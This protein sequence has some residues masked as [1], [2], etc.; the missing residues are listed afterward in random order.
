[1]EGR[2]SPC[3]ADCREDHLSTI[4]SEN[5]ASIELTGSATAVL[6][7]S[8][9]ALASG[10]LVRIIM[11]RTLPADD[12]GAFVLG[13][14][15]VSIVGGISSIGLRPATA[16]RVAEHLAAGRTPE[17]VDTSRTALV[18]GLGSGLIGVIVIAILT[19]VG[20]ERF[21]AGNPTLLIALAPVALSLALGMCVL[22][23][24]QGD[25]DTRGR[26]VFRDRPNSVCLCTPIQR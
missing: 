2:L 19:T 1:M 15:V 23:I 8:G 5:N 9:A 17:A 16:R 10:L 13:I 12:L 14:A 6:A 24:S 7:G 25:H 21:T 3:G 4:G 11:A 26:V 20:S 18:A 22:G